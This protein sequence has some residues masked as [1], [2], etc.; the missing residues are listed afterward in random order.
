[1]QLTAMSNAYQQCGVPNCDSICCITNLC[2]CQLAGGDL[3]P[4]KNA[5]LSA[6]YAALHDQMFAR[7]ERQLCLTNE[8]ACPTGTTADMYG[9]C[10]YPDMTCPPRP[11]LFGT[12]Q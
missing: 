5:I 11:S 6:T 1:V 4:A 3:T 10:N 8:V 2:A 7:V 9:V 12:C